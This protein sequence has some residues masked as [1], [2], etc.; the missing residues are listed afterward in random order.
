MSSWKGKK[1]EGRE[2]REKTW[3][4]ARKDNVLDYNYISRQCL[5]IKQRGLQHTQRKHIGAIPSG[6]IRHLTAFLWTLDPG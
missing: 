4:Y 5:M 3:K 2:K 1:G 6:P